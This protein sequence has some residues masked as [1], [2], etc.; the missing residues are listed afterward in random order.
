MIWPESIGS[1]GKLALA[2]NALA[3]FS[4]VSNLMMSPTLTTSRLWLRPYE[5]TDREGFLSLNSDGEVRRHMGGPLEE[6]RV[7]ELFETF[8]AK[9]GSA[10]W[11]VV[12]QATGRYVGHAFLNPA[13]GQ[14]GEAELGFM[15]ITGAWG[16]GYGTEIAERLL[17]CAFEG[18]NYASG[19]A[20]VDEEHLASTKVLEKSGMSLTSRGCDDLGSYRT[21]LAHRESWQA[22]LSPSND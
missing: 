20:T 21:Y 2:W 5:E 3:I 7:M 1:H 13:S 18:L 4:A 10:E 15:F 19:F 17:R 11:A 14:E 12:E 22:A 8:L 16:Q 9:T 6:P